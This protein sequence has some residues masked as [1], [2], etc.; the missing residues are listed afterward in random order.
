[1]E[2]AYRLDTYK[3]QTGDKLTGLYPDPGIVRERAP[4]LER[5][6]LNVFAD[7]CDRINDS[8]SSW[9]IDLVPANMLALNRSSANY[10]MFNVGTG[11][12]V[13][14]AGIAAILA[15]LYGKKLVPDIVNKYRSGDIRHCFR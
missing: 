7:G 12:Q 9:T 2:D 3:L 10:H 4:I 5:Y 6:K 14:I 1:M 8:N 13:S 15:G 11:K